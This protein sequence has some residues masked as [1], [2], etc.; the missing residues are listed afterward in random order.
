MIDESK[1]TKNEN[2]GFNQWPLNP[3]HCSQAEETN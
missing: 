1:E 3:N 2:L